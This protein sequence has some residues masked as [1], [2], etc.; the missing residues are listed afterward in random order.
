[1]CLGVPA[2]SITHIGVRL[3]VLPLSGGAGESLAAFSPTVNIRSEVRKCPVWDPGLKKAVN[4]RELSTGERGEFMPATPQTACRAVGFGD[5]HFKTEKWPGTQIG[6]KVRL[7]VRIW[8][9]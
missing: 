5:S 4:K 8:R 2:T 1:M 9:A 6:G 7:K 3:A